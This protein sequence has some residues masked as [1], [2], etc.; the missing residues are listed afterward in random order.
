MEGD[1]VTVRGIVG[2]GVMW[3]ERGWVVWRVG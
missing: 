1:S 2:P 3:R